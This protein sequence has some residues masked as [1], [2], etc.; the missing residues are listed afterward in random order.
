MKV[1]IGRV[2]LSLLEFLGAISCC[3]GLLKTVWKYFMGEEIQEGQQGSDIKTGT[4]SLFENEGI[5]EW[6]NQNSHL[7]VVK[8]DTPY[9]AEYVTPKGFYIRFE[10]SGESIY[11]EGIIIISQN[12]TP[13]KDEFI[14][15]ADL[16][17]KHL[18]GFP[19]ARS[20][21]QN[22]IEEIRRKF[23]EKKV[24]IEDIGQGIAIPYISSE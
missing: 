20:L 3:G 23:P 4:K 15:R 16:L 11:L 21:T 13:S 14:C 7:G 9:V 1:E 10:K 22:E 8:T 6:I 19:D 2:G 12:A 5:R 24:N 17:F 18:K